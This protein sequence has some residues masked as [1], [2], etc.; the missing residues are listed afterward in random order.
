MTENSPLKGSE[1]PKAITKGLREGLTAIR[2]LFIAT[3]AL[4]ITL[5]EKASKVF[6]QWRGDLKIQA[7]NRAATIKEEERNKREEERIAQEKAKIAEELRAEEREIRS[8]ERKLRLLKRKSVIKFIY[9]VLAAISTASLV[10]VATRLAPISKWSGSQ[11]ECI[12]TTIDFADAETDSIAYK[13]MRCN[14]G[15]D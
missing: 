3:V 1:D 9:P 7:D 4:L 8:E 15:H 11:N 12:A 2:T 10:V 13:V 6:I 5:F 14:G